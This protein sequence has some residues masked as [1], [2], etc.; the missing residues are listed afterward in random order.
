M[1][2]GYIYNEVKNILVINYEIDFS[3][4]DV[5]EYVN[6]KNN[7]IK[8]VKRSCRFCLPSG[9]KSHHLHNDLVALSSLLIIYPFIGTKNRIFVF[10]Q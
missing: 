10:N 1:K 5:T 9:F 8:L 7:T 4:G 2:I 6:H 3:S